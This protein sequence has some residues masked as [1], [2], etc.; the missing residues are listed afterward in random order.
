M[1]ALNSRIYQHIIHIIHIILITCNLSLI[2]QKSTNTNQ[3]FLHANLALCHCE[4]PSFGTNS[5]VWKRNCLCNHS[6]S[7]KKHK[8]YQQ[9]SIHI[10][11]YTIY[12]YINLL[13]LQ[14]HHLVTCCIFLCFLYL[15]LFSTRSFDCDIGRIELRSS[16]SAF[17]AFLVPFLCRFVVYSLLRLFCC[18]LQDDCVILNSVTQTKLIWISFGSIVLCFFSQG[19]ERI[20]I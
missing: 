10:Y 8:K 11:I 2:F 17:V 4:P 16:S 20:P 3:A 5:K 15:H 12:I 19:R 18:V 1:Q 6:Q 14:I 7:K 13:V 9:V